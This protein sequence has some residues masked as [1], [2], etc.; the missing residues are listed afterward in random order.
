[1]PGD[2]PAILLCCKEHCHRTHYLLRLFT[3]SGATRVC[4]DNDKL[5]WIH[6]KGLCIQCKQDEQLQQHTD[7]CNLENLLLKQSQIE[8][9]SMSC[10]MI[11]SVVCLMMLSIT[12]KLQNGK[13]RIN[14]RE[15]GKKWMWPNLRDYRGISLQRLTKKSDSGQPISRLT[16]YPRMSQKWARV[17]T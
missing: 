14:F 16:S 13:W 8:N 2:I 11:T 17:L 3:Y 12:V 1:V 5:E 4:C 10:T 6:T 9:W 7:C 15:C